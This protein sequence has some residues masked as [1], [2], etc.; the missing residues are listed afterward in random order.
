MA[1]RLMGRLPWQRLDGQWEYTLAEATRAEAGFETMVTYICQ[2]QNTFAQ[3]IVARSIL[4]LCE[5]AERN[6][7]PRVGIRW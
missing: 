1:R 5:V 2:R 3:Y 7:G 4:D 6:Q